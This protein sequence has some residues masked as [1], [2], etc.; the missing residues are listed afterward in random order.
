MVTSNPYGRAGKSLL[1]GLNWT[2]DTIKVALLNSSHVTNLDTQE[3]FADVSAN[4]VTGTG[5]TAGGQALTGKSL[6][7]YDATNNRT[8]ALAA[9]SAWD[10]TGGSLAA[11][12]AVVYKDTGV[13]AT[14]PLLAVVDNEGTITATND[15][16]TIDWNATG[17]VLAV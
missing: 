1:S 8:P 16:Y 4:E 15:L 5:Y 2:A 13:A 9:D 17:G 11:A 6:G 3:F 7:T 10:A 12:F 14:S